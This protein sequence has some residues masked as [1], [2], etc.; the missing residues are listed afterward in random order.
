MARY[1]ADEHDHD[2]SDLATYDDIRT[3]ATDGSLRV[4][5]TDDNIYVLSNNVGRCGPGRSAGRRGSSAYRRRCHRW[6]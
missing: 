2:L 5:V 3:A 6:S 1:P 4:E